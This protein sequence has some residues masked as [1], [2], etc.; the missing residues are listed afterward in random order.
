[1]RGVQPGR[2]TA[3]PD[4]KT[5]ASGSFGDDIKLW[6]VTSGKGMA[7]LKGHEGTVWSVAF[8]RDGKLL[9]SG[10]EDKTIKLWNV[11]GK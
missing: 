11:P 9:A 3:G 10:S 6:D 8:D 5:L 2:Q 7:T 4:G 1:M